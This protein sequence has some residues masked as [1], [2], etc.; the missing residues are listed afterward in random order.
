MEHLATSTVPPLALIVPPILS[1]QEETP[2][3]SHAPTT[4]RA[5]QDQACALIALP[6]KSELP[7]TLPATR[8]VPVLSPTAVCLHAAHAQQ[9]PILWTERLLAKPALLVTT[10]L[11]LVLLLALNVALEHMQQQEHPPALVAPLA[12]P[13]LLALPTCCSVLLKLLCTPASIQ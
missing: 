1:T 12:P 3:A 10:L 4:R 8:V 2:R 11:L 9:E 13:A 6:V 7:P 5:Q